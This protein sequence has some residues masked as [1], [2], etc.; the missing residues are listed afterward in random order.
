MFMRLH[1][2]LV[3]VLLAF[4]SAGE[5]A[6]QA[7]W[8]RYRAPRLGVALDFPAHIFSQDT[9]EQRPDGVIFTRRDGRAWMS[10]FGFVNRA[11]ESPMSRLN[12]MADFSSADF[13]YVRTTGRFLVASGQRGGM[14]FYRR[15]NFFAGGERWVGC[16]HLK[17]P[18]RE[19]RAWDPVVTRIS[20]SL[21]RS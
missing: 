4:F 16:F 11:N 8:E 9:A 19:K 21:G 3:A 14:I 10:I 1:P 5:A 13:D 6:A 20:H 18:A 2:P 15:C 7:R 17:Y 12:R